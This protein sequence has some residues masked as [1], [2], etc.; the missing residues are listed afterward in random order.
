MLHLRNRFRGLI[1]LLAVAGALTL[2][3]TD[4]DARAGGGFSGGSRGARTFSAPSV[5]RTAPTTA[6]PMQRTVTQPGSVG[7]P[8]AAPASG[9]LFG[10]PGGLFGGGMLGGLAAGFLGAGLFGMLFGH[11]LFGGLGGGV[12]SFFGLLLQIGLVVIVAR[13]AWAWW[14]RR[15]QPAFAGPAMRNGS[16]SGLGLNGLGLGGGSGA[17]PASGPSDQLGIK[18]ADFDA[19]EK[20][21]GEVQNAYS[22]E[23]LGVLRARVTPEMLSYF[24]EELAQNASRGVHNQVSDVHLLQGDLAEAW[25]EG[26][27]DYATVAMRFSLVDKTVERAS[28]RLVEG[29]ANPLEATELWTFRRAPGGA[30][31]L[32]AIQQA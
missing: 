26:S 13:L 14:Q 28:G 7:N 17:A 18:P 24:A 21:L 12:A 27:T 11:G 22:A 4:A 5:T 32:S 30:W 25:R 1:A 16:G 8:S 31:M 3:V 23:D 19:F 9:G 6:A 2:V 10:R 29:S 15:Q 20:L